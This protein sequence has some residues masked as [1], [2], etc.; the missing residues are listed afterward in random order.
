M[1]DWIDLIG[2]AIR[3]WRLYRRAAG[4]RRTEWP[5][6]AEMNPGLTLLGGLGL[7]A[8]LMYLFDPARG[9]RRRAL[10]RDQLVHASRV[11]ARALPTTRRDLRQRTYGLLAESSRLLPHPEVSNEILEAR[12]RSKIGRS[13]SHPHAISVAVD[14]GVVTLSGMVLDR[15]ARRMISGVSSVRGVRYV[16]NLLEVHHEDEEIPAL[17]GGRPR[18]GDRSA[19]RQSNWSPATRLLTGMTGGVLMA[20]C[21]ARRDPLSTALGALGFGI[22]M[23]GV[24]NME[25]K[26]LIGVGRDCRTF[27]VQKTISIKA[28]VARV[29]EF[30]TNYQNFPRFMSR[31]REVIPSGE[32]R[33]RWLVY[34]P[35][36]MPIEWTSEITAMVPDKLLAWRS[37]PGSAIDHSGAIHFESREDGGTRIQIQMCY[38]PLGGALGHTLARMLGSDPKSE[39]DADMV[40]MKTFIETGHPPHDA[41]KTPDPFAAKQQAKAVRPSPS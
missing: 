40:R 29:F 4:G 16:E 22:F 26:S 37:L 9:K 10:M 19:L 12:V 38:R 35:A 41:A 28:P 18:T 32:G 11:L 34:G 6:L 21:L 30:W 20:N 23:R 13:V 33:S 1:S 2:P 5:Q 27:A 14:D 3:G 25:L 8:G 31:V 7:G 39:L 36:G 15:E 17:Q 24:T